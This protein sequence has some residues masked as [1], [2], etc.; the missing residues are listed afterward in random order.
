MKRLIH[1]VLH[2]DKRA[3]ARLIS[4]VENDRKIARAVM[5]DIKPH[6]GKAR[7]VGVT[8]APGSGKST[9]INGMISILR[10]RGKK[11]GVI[12]IDPT[13]PLSGG[14]LLGDRIR[15]HDHANDDG[16]FV[17]SMA[18]REGT[19]GLSLAAKDAAAILA[20]LGMDTVFLETTGV[21]QS[22]TAV[23]Q[24][25]QTVV[26]V[27]IPNMGD[28]IQMM[29]AGIMEIGDVLVV[30]K[31]DLPN[32]KTMVQEL[33]TMVRL[34]P[35]NRPRPTVVMTTADEGKGLERLMEAVEKAGIGH[36]SL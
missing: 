34:R 24:A 13:S 8:G 2:G 17:R 6:I 32:A 15:M 36:G 30:N 12:S 19:G 20:A 22:E 28:D 25:V 27:V 16:V 18:T 3:A 26:V 11:V 14:A 29:K 5:K 33:N 1:E 31:G 7:F 35:G 10:N 4:I 23:R 21:G 9:L